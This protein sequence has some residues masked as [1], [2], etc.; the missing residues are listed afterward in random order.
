V[1][2]GALP[3][4]EATLLADTDTDTDTDADADADTD[5]HVHLGKDSGKHPAPD[6]LKEPAALGHGPAAAGAPATPQV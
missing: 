4:D 5:P 6:P 2:A 3:F 1:L